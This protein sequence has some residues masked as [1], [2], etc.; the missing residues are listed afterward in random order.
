[1]TKMAAFESN[2]QLFFKDYFGDDYENAF[3][4][5]MFGNWHRVKD[6]KL[7]TTDNA[8]KWLR[9]DVSYDY[10]SQKVRENDCQFGVVKTAHK[11]KLGNVQKMSYQMINAL[12]VDKTE[13]LILFGSTSESRFGSFPTSD[14]NLAFL[15]I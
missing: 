5:D 10:W 8:A 1:M 3:V 12:D 4:E 6:I 15:F 11:S 14:K 7:I 13:V 2:I 9:F